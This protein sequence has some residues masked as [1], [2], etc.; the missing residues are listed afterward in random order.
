M[1]LW[2]QHYLCTCTK[3]GTFGCSDTS[4]YINMKNVC[5]VLMSWVLLLYCYIEWTCYVPRQASFSFP[6]RPASEMCCSRPRRICTVVVLL[7]G[8]CAVCTDDSGL[9]LLPVV[10]YWYRYG[11][12]QPTEMI[13]LTH[14]TWRSAD[15]VLQKQRAF[16]NAD[17]I[18]SNT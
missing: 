16:F 7:A 14:S 13:G 6:P 12:R 10:L 9:V 4:L 15:T 5:S 1:F 2:S 18:A 11:T 3:R 17:C 8:Y